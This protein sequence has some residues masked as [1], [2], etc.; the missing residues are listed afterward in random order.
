MAFARMERISTAIGVAAAHVA[1]A[2]GVEHAEVPLKCS[3]W[4]S[5]SPT[6][7]PGSRTTLGARPRP[8]PTVDCG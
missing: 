7:R 1:H 4:W 2:A 5:A 6:S 8:R 3:P